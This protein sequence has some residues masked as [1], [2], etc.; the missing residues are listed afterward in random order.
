MFVD[1]ISGV[2]TLYI[3]NSMIRFSMMGSSQ[4]VRSSSFMLRFGFLTQ[5]GAEVNAKVR[6]GFMGRWE[7]NAIFC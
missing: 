7:E 5:R 6:G 1:V 2:N 3:S 4:G